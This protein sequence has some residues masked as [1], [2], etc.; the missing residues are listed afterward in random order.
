MRELAAHRV[1]LVSAALP[2]V[3]ITGRR[4]TL[5]GRTRG[6]TIDRTVRRLLAPL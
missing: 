3:I 1:R 2:A 4:I 5:R 6:K